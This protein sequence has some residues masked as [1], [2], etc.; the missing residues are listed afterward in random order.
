MEQT[1]PHAFFL[2]EK[3]EWRLLEKGTEGIFNW[4]GNVLVLELD[5]RYIDIHYIILYFSLCVI[6]AYKFI[7]ISPIGKSE[8]KRGL[9][10]N[11]GVGQKKKSQQKRVK[12]KTEEEN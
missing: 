1:I 10:M 4:A 5:D 12:K 2:W 9:K 7:R 3:G 8:D 11:P 6:F